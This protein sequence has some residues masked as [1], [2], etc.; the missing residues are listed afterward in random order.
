MRVLVDAHHSGRQLSVGAARRCSDH[1][2]TAAGTAG[3]RP[4]ERSAASRPLAVKTFM[5]HRCPRRP[6]Q[7]LAWQLASDT[8]R[9]SRTRGTVSDMS[10]AIMTTRPLRM[11]SSG[12]AGSLAA[13]GG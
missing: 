7:D 3:C 5:R 1:P 12:S 4:A 6:G 2:G 11:S 8:G 10:T 13:I 9:V